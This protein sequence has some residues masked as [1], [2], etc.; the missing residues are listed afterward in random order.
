MHECKSIY[1]RAY[2]STAEKDR[3]HD[4]TTRSDLHHTLH[5]EFKFSSS[6]QFSTDAE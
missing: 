1:K 2:I 5:Q 6:F 3:R 4:L